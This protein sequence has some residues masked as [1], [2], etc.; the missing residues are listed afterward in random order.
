M[1]VYISADM[2]GTSGITGPDDVSPG[3]PAYERFRK[4]LTK[5][6]NAAIEGAIKGG[7]SQIL[8]NEAHNGMRN[9]LIEELNPKAEMISGFTKPLCMM[10]GI[11]NSFDAVFLVAYHAMAGT[12]A[13]ILNHTLWGKEILNIRVNDRPVGETALSSMAAGYFGA[14]VVLVTGDDKVAKEAKDLLGD[15]E[16]AVV[17]EG[18]D[19]YVAKCLTPEE[20]AKRIREAAE[21]ALGRVKEFKPYKPRTPIRFEV[22]FV[23]TAIAATATLIPGIKKENPRTISF[24]SEDVFEGYKELFAALL[25]ANTSADP[26]FG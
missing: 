26:T 6:V 10:E 1:R 8:V 24:T 3:K 2:E 12:E 5:D 7:A 17:K 19:R 20:S 23:S 13:A 11:D 21:R 18:I 4:L 9:I 16:T 25:L 14:P 22:D 15:I